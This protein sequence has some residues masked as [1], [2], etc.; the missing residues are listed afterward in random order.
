VPATPGSALVIMFQMSW[1][2]MP[3][4]SV[5]VVRTPRSTLREGRL[6]ARQKFCSPLIQTTHEKGWRSPDP[7]LVQSLK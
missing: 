3:S 1:C 2:M 4:P 5:M 6:V 7:S